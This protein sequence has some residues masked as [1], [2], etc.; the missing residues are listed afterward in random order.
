MEQFR[1]EYMELFIMKF[2]DKFLSTRIPVLTQEKFGGIFK[3]ILEE[4]I[5]R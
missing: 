1:R 5:L 4:K 2:L 3:E